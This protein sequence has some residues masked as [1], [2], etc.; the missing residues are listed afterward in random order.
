MRPDCDQILAL[1]MVA[2][3]A[4]EV[5]P[6]DGEQSELLNTIKVPRN[7]YLLTDKLPKPTYEGFNKKLN[8]RVR[9][10]DHSLIDTDS[11]LPNINKNDLKTGL[12]DDN[13]L[14][15]KPS[16]SSK[17]KLKGISENEE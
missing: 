14:E 1:P 11:I 4:N 12:N 13:I 2:K 9:S 7:L 15:R 6:F 5:L 8:R 3:R 16:N 17:L 10:Q